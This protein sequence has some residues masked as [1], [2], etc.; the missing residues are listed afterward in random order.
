MYYYKVRLSQYVSR[1]HILLYVN[2]DGVLRERCKY[3]LRG[4]N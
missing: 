2:Y 4:I 3:H 1:M